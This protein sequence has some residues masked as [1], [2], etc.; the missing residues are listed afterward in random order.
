M[1]FDT[2]LLILICP[3][4]STSTF[5]T[6]YLELE[7]DGSFPY[8]YMIT[9]LPRYFEK[10]EG[11]YAYLTD[12]YENL[13]QISSLAMLNVLAMILDLIWILR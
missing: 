1:A 12:E 10:A 13:D 2:S 8:P 7:S 5:P 6:E 11:L 9:C 3:S 4:I